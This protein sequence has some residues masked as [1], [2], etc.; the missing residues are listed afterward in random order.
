MRIIDRLLTYLSFKKITPYSF[1][2]NCKVANGYLKKQQKGKGSI[3]SDILERI[4]QE[5]LDLS[6][7][8]LIAGTGD[9]IIV[10]DGS[11]DLQGMVRESRQ[12]Y[13]R[14]ERLMALSER[15]ALL[16][17]ALIDKDKI[18]HLLEKSAG[19]KAEKE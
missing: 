12:H 4:H 14:E 3:G 5:Y 17:K 15:V 7:V 6:L 2:R 18:I 16:E 9:M 10:N 1:E 13:S 8:W 19:I 11:D